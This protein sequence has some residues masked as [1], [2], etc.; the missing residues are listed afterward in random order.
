MFGPSQLV[1]GSERFSS[2]ARGDMIW[3]NVCLTMFRPQAL[4]D[5]MLRPAIDNPLVSSI[6]FICDEKEKSLWESDVAPKLRQCRT[7]DKVKEPKW[8]TL[9]EPLSFILSHGDGITMEALL[10]FWG[11]PFMARTT[12]RD[13]P[14]Y[15]FYV[16]SNSELL[17]RLAELERDYRMR[18]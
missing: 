2:R 12:E 10:S 13:V 14:R 9:N 17:P 1:S 8:C 15:I 6:L 16:P 5:T 3:F 18:P 4:F 7:P 11:E